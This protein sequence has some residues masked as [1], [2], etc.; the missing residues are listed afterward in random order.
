[1][2]FHA[3][4]SIIADINAMSPTFLRM[5]S[6]QASLQLGSLNGQTASKKVFR[7]LESLIPFRSDIKDASQVYENNNK[8]VI[9][10]ITR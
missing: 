4:P 10:N 9:L 2:L 6:I 1:M 7:I 5:K 8:L 3:L